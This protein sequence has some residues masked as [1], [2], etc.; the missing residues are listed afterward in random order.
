LTIACL[1]IKNVNLEWDLEDPN[2]VIPAHEM[3]EVKV[4]THEDDIEPAHTLEEHAP[5]KGDEQ[6]HA[7]HIDQSPN[8]E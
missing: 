8:T 1:P 3:H 7:E 6:G 5:A 2:Q 4:H